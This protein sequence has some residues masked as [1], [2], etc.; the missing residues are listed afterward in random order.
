MN[1]PTEVPGSHN[2]QTLYIVHGPP[3]CR[4]SDVA[5]RLKDD[6]TVICFTD[7]YFVNNGVYNFLPEKLAE[8]HARN[9]SAAKAGLDLGFSVIVDSTDSGPWE[10]REYVRHAAS[11]GIPVMFIRVTGNSQSVHGVPR[12]GLTP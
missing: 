2:C 6:N 9:V 7:S 3:G 11:K 4:K 1:S 5:E 10:C 8:Y 12:N